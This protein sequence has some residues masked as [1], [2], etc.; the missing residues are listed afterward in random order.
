MQEDTDKANKHSSVLERGF[1]TELRKLLA[2][3]MGI[4]LILPR[5]DG[6]VTLLRKGII[7][8]PTQLPVKADGH[9]FNWQHRTA[10]V[11]MSFGQRCTFSSLPMRHLLKLD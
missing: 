8:F 10:G 6:K 3:P 7:P 1:K 9:R 2:V 5:G 4:P 11:Q